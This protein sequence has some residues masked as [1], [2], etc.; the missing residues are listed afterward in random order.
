ML[1]NIKICTIEKKGNRIK[2]YTKYSFIFW[3]LLGGTSG[4]DTGGRPRSGK[5]FSRTPKL[6]QNP[7]YEN[8]LLAPPSYGHNDS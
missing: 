5:R 7:R 1:Q 6:R 2:I 4:T 8:P 3:G